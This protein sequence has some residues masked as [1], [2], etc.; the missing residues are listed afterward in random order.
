M[1]QIVP[2]EL[3]D[4]GSL[5]DF[6]PSRSKSSDD[7]KDTHSSCGLF[8]PAPQYAQGFLIERHMTGLATLR[9]PALDGEKPTVEVHGTPT[10]LEN[11]AAPQSRV[12]R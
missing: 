9:I 8:A 2:A 11:L 5:E 10:Q 4:P 12:H 6:L 1:P 3:A 7:I